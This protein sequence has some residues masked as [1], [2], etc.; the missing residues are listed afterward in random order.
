MHDW[1]LQR[2]F[3]YWDQ[4]ANAIAQYSLELSQLGEP[5]RATASGRIRESVSGHAQALSDDHLLKMAVSL[6][7]DLYQFLNTDVVVRAAFF[8]YLEA[9]GRTFTSVLRD[10]GYV[11]RYV[12]ENQFADPEIVMMGPLRLF[13]AA[14]HAV[15]C[16]Y[17]CPQLFA[18]KM[19]QH[20]G[21]AESD[22][23]SRIA[24]YIADGRAVASQLARDCRAGNRHYIFL[25][26]DYEDGA[27]EAA[28]E[29]AGE[30]G[31]LRLFRNDAPVARSQIEIDFP[32][33]KIHG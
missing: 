22:Y 32:A 5:A 21:L 10:R 12:I 4:S 23:P 29:G 30:A 6:I 8:D 26:A 14:F 15:G 24:H 3:E 9:M 27:L 20:D 19:M 33:A 16:V 1:K 11:I 31:A 18:W 25:E 13:P 7:D 28:L 17:V 2:V